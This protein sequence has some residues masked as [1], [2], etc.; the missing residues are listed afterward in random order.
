MQI[1]RRDPPI[2]P[3]ARGASSVPEPRFGLAV[4]RKVGNAVV[5]NRVKRHLREAAR[6]LRARVGG[7]DVVIIARAAA[8]E[9]SGATL[10]ADL[11]RLL[12]A[13]GA[14]RAPESTP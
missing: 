1:A 11:E 13:L 9:A 14:L 2:E 10:R 8:A 7:V 6:H 4:S 12:G 5:R 3:A